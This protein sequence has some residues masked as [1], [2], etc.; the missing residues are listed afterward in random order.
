V[1]EPQR[2]LRVAASL[3][4]PSW[5]RPFSYRCFARSQN[6]RTVEMRYGR[7]VRC[8]TGRWALASAASGQDV[9]HQEGDDDDRRRDSNDGDGGGGDNH[10]AILAS[11]FQVGLNRGHLRGGIDHLVRAWPHLPTP[12]L[13][14]A[15][16]EPFARV[17]GLRPQEA[18]RPGMA[19]VSTVADTSGFATA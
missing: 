18:S 10:P 4:G 5:A 1:G 16:R 13:G 6:P 14:P 17:R 19:A 3:R 15:L 12:D 9:Q 11:S 8:L 2:D 7:L